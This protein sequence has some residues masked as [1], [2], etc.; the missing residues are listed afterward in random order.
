ML[1]TVHLN[2]LCLLAVLL[3]NDNG[4]TGEIPSEIGLLTK[5][6]SLLLSGNELSGM[7]PTEMGQLTLLGELRPTPIVLV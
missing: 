1:R 3:L 2:F 5:L 7:V 4:L 6:S